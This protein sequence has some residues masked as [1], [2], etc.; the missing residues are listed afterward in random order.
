MDIM[1]IVSLVLG[2][3]LLIGFLLGVLRAWKKSL[4]RMAFIIVSFVG[5]FLLSSKVSKFL[6]SRYV[7]G[8]VVSLFGQTID[9]E[10]I[11]GDL[12]G[13]LLGEGSAL[14]N[15]A[16]ALLNIFIKIIAFLI[17]FLSLFIVTLIIYWVISAIMS[18]RKKKKSV[19]NEKPKVWERF[20]GGGIGIIST[21]I[22][23]VALFSPVFGVMNVCDKFLED[24]T[25]AAASAYNGTSF[26]AGKF[27]T[28][29]ENIGQVETY[30]QKYDKLR[31]NYKKSFAGIAFTYTGTDAL[32]KFTFNKIST[33]TCNGMKVNFTTE[34]VN[35]IKVYNIYKEN[36][37]KTKFN[38]ANE[39]SVQALENIYGIARESEVLRSFVVDLV[40][41]MANKWSNGETFLNMKL[42][43]SGDMEEIFVEM[44]GV[45]DS[46]DFNV[47]DR[48]INVM[49]D[50]IK[51]ANQHEIIASVNDGDSILDVI[52]TDTFVK[53]EIKTIASTPEFKRALPNIM[54][55]TIKLAYKSMLGDPGTK[56]DQ[57]FT[58]QQISAIDW[59]DESTYTQNIVTRMF[60]FFDTAD[61]IDC[62]SD[63]G[64]VIDNARESKILSKPVKI[65][66][67]DYIDLKITTLGKSKQTLLNAINDK[68][69]EPDYKFEDLFTTIEV[70]AKLSKD[71]GSMDAS[72]MST[73]IKNLLSSADT[74]AT[75]KQAVN[76]GI[77][78]ELIQDED[79]AQ[80]YKDVLYSV[81]DSSDNTTIDQDLEAAQVV[82]DIINASSS[83][84][85]LLDTEN[86]PNVTQE[87]KADVLVQTLISSETIMTTLETSNETNAIVKG[88]I[89]GLD[90]DEK[91][92]IQEDIA[93][94]QLIATDP[95]KIE[96]L[97]TLGRLFA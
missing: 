35:V 10:S 97:S 16:T 80:V 70:T 47:L 74:V 20:V 4:I 81:L 17:I 19:G 29:N 36:F 92:I 52:D 28:E 82:V 85:S 9:F 18:S 51:V 58:Q 88:Y 50:V 30:L 91:R 56:L 24:D 87:D 75:L 13:D 14:T 76:D 26:V 45:F 66:M 21:F 54:T 1:S 41:K 22:L 34:C 55:T 40:P 6:M 71:V 8:L 72:D 43:V 3:L 49:F 5:A 38:M 90:A 31:K 39:S 48:N 94:K 73:S 69:S 65:L 25:K 15:F 37:V 7:N 64:V 93:Q 42:P 33:V 89:S 32:G 62:L 86:N 96:Y 83:N 2:A 27:Y 60:K 84:G 63:F 77:L 78:N 95:N 53:D 59:D 67:L 61:V 12:A 68:W 79:K 44:L 11:A 46:K 23:C 57:E